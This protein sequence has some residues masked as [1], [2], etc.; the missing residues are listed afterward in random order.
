[1][2]GVDKSFPVGG[3]LVRVETYLSVGVPDRPV[4]GT[5]ASRHARVQ[6]RVYVRIG[7]GARCLWATL[8]PLLVTVTVIFAVFDCD[9]RV[10]V[11]NWSV[12]GTVASFVAVAWTHR[13][14]VGTCRHTVFTT[15]TIRPQSTPVTFYAE[16]CR[17]ASLSVQFPMTLACLTFKRLARV[18]TVTGLTSL[19]VKCQILSLWTW[20]S[21]HHIGTDYIG[22]LYS[23]QLY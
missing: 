19:F 23:V 8:C 3:T 17:S 6:G 21:T 20:L 22:T 9:A 16:R 13:H 14:G 1:M 4:L 10:V 15:A 2:Y 18:V 11:P 5:L 7:A 12:G